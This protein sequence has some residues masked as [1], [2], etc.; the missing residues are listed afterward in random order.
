VSYTLDTLYINRVISPWNSLPI[1]EMG[2]S[3]FDINL[4]LHTGFETADMRMGA[5]YP[6]VIE[7]HS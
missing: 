7:L 1:D 3:S 6:D 4:L 5:Y 2:L